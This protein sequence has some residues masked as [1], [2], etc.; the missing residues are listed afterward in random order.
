LDLT[1]SPETGF[2]AGQLAEALRRQMSTTPGGRVAYVIHNRKIAS[3]IQ[4]WKWRP[5]GGDNPHTGHVHISIVKALRYE[6]RPW[7]LN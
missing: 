3:P 2:D 7:K 5:Y 4:G 1:H 6:N